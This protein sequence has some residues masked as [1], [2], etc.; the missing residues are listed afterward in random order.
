MKKILCLLLAL[1]MLCAC[2]VSCDGDDEIGPGDQNYD[3]TWESLDFGDAKLTVSVSANDPRETTFQNSA[4][5]MKGPDKAATS[6][7][8]QKKV[9]ARNKKVADDLDIAIDYQTTN[10][11]YSEILP[12]LEI[13]VGG[14]AADAPDV[15]NND[16][17]ALFRGMM[18]GY[19]WNVTD[20]GID[21]KGDEVKSYFDLDHECWYKTYMEGA[22]FSKDKQYILIGDYNIDIVRFAWVFFVN[23]DLWDSTF[24]NLTEEDG[25]GYNTYE[26][27]CDFIEDTQDWFYDDL[28]AL[29][30]MAHRDGVDGTL[31]KT[32]KND[33]Q[34]GLTLNAC[35]ARLFTYGS[36]Y[37][38]FEWTKNGK[39]V[40]EGEGVPGMI[41]DTSNMVAVANK[42]KELYNTKGVYHFGEE[43]ENSNLDTVV[44]FM[45]GKTI[46][47]MACLGEMES[48]QMRDT[49]FTRG[50]LPFPR[51]SRDIPNLTTVVHDQ[52]EVSA[53]LNNAKSF[54]M[55]SAF[56]QYVNEES[57]EILDFY[58]EDV[59]K[60]KY[61]ESRGARKMIDLVNET[62]TT[63]FEAL[64]N[65]YLFDEAGVAALFQTVTN[66]AK[67][68]V[69]STLRSKYDAARG[70]LQIKLDELYEKF[71]ALQ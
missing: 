34:I 70:S 54:S 33:D 43:L 55:A 12:H 16:I 11:K 36:G 9:L 44:H 39:T 64:M 37:S 49:S 71:S 68:N 52:A 6:E 1:C 63:P 65:L 29:A 14:D 57:T 13:L 19:L 62:V 66:E 59:L 3:G 18:A 40:G 7:P 46:M 31:D 8:V 28:I 4:V 30:G 22:T 56:L 25:W 32:D 48:S 5:Y 61:N 41:T 21:A 69:D 35:A 42:Y 26:T 58:Y 45:D 27:A 47:A 24:G 53:I 67:K 50:I 23:V 38:I 10:W 20:P 2:F 15:Y 17:Y 60:F 51:Y